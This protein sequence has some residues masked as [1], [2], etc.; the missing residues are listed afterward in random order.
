MLIY[1]DAP[2]NAISDN[3]PSSE[4]LTSQSQIQV[5]PKSE[6]LTQRALYL[7]ST[8]EISSKQRHD[9]ISTT[10]QRCSNVRCPLGSRSLEIK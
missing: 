4:M 7:A 9:L 3:E 10:F 6:D 8:S 5:M 1:I 2:D